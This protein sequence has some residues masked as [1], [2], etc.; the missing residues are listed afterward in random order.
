MLMMFNSQ[1]RMCRRIEAEIPDMEAKSCIEVNLMK[2]KVLSSRKE[3]KAL[4]AS[5]K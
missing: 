5:K 1:N 4:L 3:N 2:A